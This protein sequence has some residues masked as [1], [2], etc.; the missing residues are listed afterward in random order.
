MQDLVRGVR[1]VRNRYQVEPKVKLDVSVKCAGEVAA[2][3]TALAPFIGPLAG[4]GG[5]VAGPDAAKPKQAGT[6][7]RPDFEA[8]ISL[9]GLID[10]AAERKRL[11]KQI[12]DAKKQVGGMQAKLSN[13]SYVKNAPPEV[14][15]ETKA[16]AAEIEG[17]IRMLEENLKD[18]QDG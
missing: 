8:Y 4:V 7:V 2:D 17:Q 12:A 11:E 5:F 13:E 9:A 6:V 15:E 10:P 16:K 3:F 1:E 18:L 14:V